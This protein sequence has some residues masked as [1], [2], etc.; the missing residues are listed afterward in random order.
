[1][2]V[3]WTALVAILILV[4]GWVAVWSWIITAIINAAG[5]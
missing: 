2:K 1:M 4:V 5:Q 3:N